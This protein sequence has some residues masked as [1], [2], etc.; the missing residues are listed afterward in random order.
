VTNDLSNSENVIV[1]NFA[2]NDN[3]YQAM[4]LL[5]ELDSQRQVD[6]A[7]AAVVVRDDDGHVLVKDDVAD[8]RHTATLGGG[9]VGLLIGVIGGPFGV[10]IGGA[11]GVLVGSLFDSHDGDETESALSDV[12]ASVQVG[13][14]ALLAEVTEQGTEVIDTAMR[15][16][17]GEI[18][19]RSLDDVEAEIAATEKAQ[20]S[21]K[22]EARK[23][24]VKERQE[25]H[26]DEIRA[27]IEELKAKL[28]GHKK[29]SATAA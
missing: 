19:R 6:L 1:V 23:Q 4:T 11:T 15:G 9:L 20:R 21:A 27:K 29:E 5:R 26:R 16:I 10:L 8:E 14:T 28:H 2:E 18:L 7:A 17:G 22:R 3:A 13:R 25:K 12:S 24:L